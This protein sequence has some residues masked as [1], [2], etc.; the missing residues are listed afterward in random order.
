MVA[1]IVQEA[2]PVRVILFGSH[3]LGRPR[4]DSDFDLL[5]ILPEVRDRHAEMVRLRGAVGRIGVPVDVLV[6]SAREVEE[7]G[8]VQGTVLYPALHEGQV[9]YEVA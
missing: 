6:Y 3:V 9:L 1:R 7:W 2:G 5:V 8:D 4:E